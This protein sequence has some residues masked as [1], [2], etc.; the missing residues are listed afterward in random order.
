MGSRLGA[1]LPSTG[2]TP[3]KGWMCK[4]SSRGCPSAILNADKA[5]RPYLF[6]ESTDREFEWIC[7]LI[8]RFARLRIGAP[9]SIAVS[10]VLC[11]DLDPALNGICQC[12]GVNDSCYADERFFATNEFQSVP[13]SLEAAGL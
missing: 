13:E 5:G 3:C 12:S 10:K 1:Y 9:A 4:N 6:Q 7:L 11:F 2:D 8:F